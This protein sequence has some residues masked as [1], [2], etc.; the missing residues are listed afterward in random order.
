[1]AG[2]GALRWSEDGG[3]SRSCSMPR[4][5]AG[6]V[7]ERFGEALRRVNLAGF[8]TGAPL[9]PVRAADVTPYRLRSSAPHRGAD[10]GRGRRCRKRPRSTVRARNHEGHG[11]RAHRGG[12]PCAPRSDGRRMP[13]SPLAFHAA[14][15]RGL[16]L[17]AEETARGFFTPRKRASPGERSGGAAPGNLH[18]RRRPPR[19]P[20]DGRLRPAAGARVETQGV[21]QG[22]WIVSRGG[23]RPSG[24]LPARSQDRRRRAGRPVPHRVRGEGRPPD[25]RYVSGRGTRRPGGAFLARRRGFPGGCRFGIGFRVRQDLEENP[26]AGFRETR[27]CSSCPT[28][29]SP[30]P[31]RRRVNR[32][33]SSEWRAGSPAPRTSPPSGGFSR[34]AGTR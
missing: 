27:R 4:T 33:P 30:V 34:R 2:S 11:F 17:E 12:R 23:G 28:S 5:A 20:E 3:T 22:D 24:T 14:K 19:L 9:T 21:L 26:G 15:E 16:A 7:E 8:V 31:R 13:N 29:L 1:M 25:S 6:K 32:S 10:A 18:R